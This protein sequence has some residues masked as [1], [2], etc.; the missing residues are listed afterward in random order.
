MRPF[1]ET[2]GSVEKGPLT[3]T[4]NLFCWLLM[5]VLLIKLDR[6]TGCVGGCDDN[7]R[8]LLD[9]KDLTRLPSESGKSSIHTMF[10]LFIKETI[11]SPDQ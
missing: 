4:C 9:L 2:I 10:L 7:L 1:S 3:C 11:V 6:Y 5:I 8:E